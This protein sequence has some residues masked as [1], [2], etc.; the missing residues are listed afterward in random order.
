MNFIEELKE[1]FDAYLSNRKF[2]P[3]YEFD[4]KKTENLIN[5]LSK[6]K[7]CIVDGYAESFEYIAR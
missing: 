2:I 5:D 6:E 4:I 1:K 3:A 7:N